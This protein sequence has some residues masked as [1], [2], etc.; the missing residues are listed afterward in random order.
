MKR[1]SSGDLWILM[2]NCDVV[3]TITLAKENLRQ[4]YLY[5]EKL[6]LPV[7]VPDNGY[8]SFDYMV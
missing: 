2:G 6:P 8:L 3:D 4:F 1:V 7:T 5:M